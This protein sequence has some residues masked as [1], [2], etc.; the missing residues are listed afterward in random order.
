V[1][2]AVVHGDRGN[3]GVAHAGLDRGEGGLHRAVLH[4]GGAADELQLLGALD[5]L[6]A[7]DQFARVDIFGARELLHNEVPIANDIW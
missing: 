6:D 1:I 3:F 5:H 7:V 2:L 4:D